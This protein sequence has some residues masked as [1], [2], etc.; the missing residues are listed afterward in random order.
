MTSQKNP[1]INFELDVSTGTRRADL[2]CD[3][4]AVPLV[5][6]IHTVCIDSFDSF[7]GRYHE[8]ASHT[9]QCINVND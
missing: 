7:K 3:L 8:N 1:T 9:S 4:T 6:N 2:T 5:L